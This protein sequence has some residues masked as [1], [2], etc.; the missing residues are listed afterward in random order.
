MIKGYLFDYGGTLDTQG[1]HWGKVIWHA[2]ERFGVP[3]RWEHFKDAYVHG[4]RTLGSQSIIQPDDTFRTTLATK[5]DL[6][7][8]YL[9]NHQL[10]TDDRVDLDN[11]KS[12]L[13]EALYAQT[14]NVV[15]ESREMLALLKK[16]YPLALVSNFYGNLETV[17]EEMHLRDVFDHVV[18]SAVVSVRKPDPQIFVIALERMGLAAADVMVVGDSMKN[19]IAPAQSLGCQTTWIRGEE[20]KD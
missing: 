11:A 7:L 4:E 1:C 10:F 3:V 2:Y 13:L 15:E 12:Q 8:D 19:D 17:L 18:E 20:W 5:L 16:R 6:Q 14:C 9:S